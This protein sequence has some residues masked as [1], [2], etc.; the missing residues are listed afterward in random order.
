[1]RRIVFYILTICLILGCEKKYS[2]TESG[3]EYHIYSLG[4]GERL[5]A[6][7]DYVLVRQALT[8]YNGMLLKQGNQIYRVTDT[9]DADIN[10][11]LKLLMRGDSAS[12]IIYRSHRTISDSLVPRKLEVKILNIMSK[13][14]YDESMLELENFY[15]EIEEEELKA[16]L[17][18]SSLDMNYQEGMY[19]V[20]EDTG[21]GDA[22]KGGDL[23]QVHYKG[24]FLNGQLFDSSY[25]SDKPLEFQYGYPNQ[26]IRGFELAI[27]RMKSGGKAKIIL[28]SH[29]AFGTEGSVSGIVPPFTPVIYELE[30]VGHTPFVENEPS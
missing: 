6:A 5:A 30:I 14:A 23:V 25:D 22:I 20:M 11:G 3:L 8:D 9:L 29:L 28:P 19:Y 12:F 2:K 21:E 7:G 13:A 16:F 15:R 18:S 26:V 24:Y 17:D 4:D 27:H 1:M 10:E